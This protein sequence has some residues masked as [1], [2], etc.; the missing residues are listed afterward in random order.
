VAVVNALYLPLRCVCSR[1]LVTHAAH[2][3]CLRSQKPFWADSFWAFKNDDDGYSLLTHNLVI[4]PPDQNSVTDTLHTS[5][6]VPTSGLSG[7]Q[8]SVQ[9]KTM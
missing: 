5:P 8:V 2:A 1:M 4:P 9:K 7:H 3:A 6:E